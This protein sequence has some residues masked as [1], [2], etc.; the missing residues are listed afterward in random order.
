MKTAKKIKELSSYCKNSLVFTQY[1]LGWEISSYEDN[2]L[3]HCG[4]KLYKK[5]HG[6]L[7][8]KSFKRLVDEAYNIMLADEKGE[9]NEQIITLPMW[10]SASQYLYRKGQ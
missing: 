6:C 5:N 1:S 10:S 9:Q 2:T 7:E 8:N 4:N 3:F